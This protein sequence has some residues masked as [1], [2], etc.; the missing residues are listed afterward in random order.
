MHI[1]THIFPHNFHNFVRFEG[2]ISEVLTFFFTKI[3][4]YGEGV[5]VHISMRNSLIEMLCKCFSYFS[6]EKGCA[7]G[8]NLY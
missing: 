2:V 7:V 3:I 8:A 1:R 4:Y 6:I 5:K